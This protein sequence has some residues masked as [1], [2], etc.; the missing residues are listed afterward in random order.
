[1]EMPAKC[2]HTLGGAQT[3]EKQ[4]NR[5]KTG[6]NTGEVWRCRVSAHTTWRRANRGKT[7]TIKQVK[8][9]DAAKCQHTQLGGAQ[10]GKKQAL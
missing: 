4:V 6:T 2:Q 10:T 7:G 8:Y 3:G 9:G 5:G 1:M